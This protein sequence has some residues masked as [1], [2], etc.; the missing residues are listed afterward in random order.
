MFAALWPLAPAEVKPAAGESAT[1][2]ARTGC[3]SSTARVQD[4]RLVVRKPNTADY[5]IELGA[6]PDVSRL[7][8]RVVGAERPSEPRDSRRDRDMEAIWCSEFT[9]LQQLLTDSGGEVLLERA[10]EAGVQPVKTVP[11]PETDREV[12]RNAQ[13]MQRSQ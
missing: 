8:L 2:S 12:R 6:S 3:Q 11:F 1:L 5:G 7:Q 4:G 13:Q 9:Q 10:V